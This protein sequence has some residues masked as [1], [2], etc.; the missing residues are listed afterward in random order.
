VRCDVVVVGGSGDCVLAA[1]LSED[2][3]RTVLSVEADPDHAGITTL[4]PD[5][6]DSSQPTFEH[7]SG[8]T[9]DAS[10]MPTVPTGTQNLPTFMVTEHFARWLRSS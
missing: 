10:L 2:A 3:D 5:G 6:L 1:W 7:D 4:T 8:Y 9:A